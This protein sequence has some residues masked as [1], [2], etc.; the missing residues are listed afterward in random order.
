MSLEYSPEHL[1]N[2]FIVI[3][4][5]GTGSRIVAQLC[6]LI[7]SIDWVRDR[8]PMIHVFDDDVVE[9][10]N[11]TRQLFSKADV[12]KFKADAVAERYSKQYGLTVTAHKTRITDEATLIRSIRGSIMAEGYN[13]QDTV[14]RMVRP[15]L[16][17]LAVDTI[18]ARR[19]ILAAI[20]QMY[21]PFNMVV[22]DP[23]NEDSFGQV[24]V[25][26]P[27]C[28]PIHSSL[29]GYAANHLSWINNIPDFH[30]HP[31]KLN[32][33]PMPIMHY[34]QTTETGGTGSCAD[35][36]QTLALNSIMASACIAVAQSLMLCRPHQT[37]T[38]Y[39]DL[40]MANRSETMNLPWLRG[41]CQGNNTDYLTKDNLYE[42]LD[43][44]PDK[45]SK[46]EFLDKVLFHECAW[47]GTKDAIRAHLTLGQI[48]LLKN[49]IFMPCM[50]LEDFTASNLTRLETARMETIEAEE[51]ARAEAR[52]L[53]L[54]QQQADAI[55]SVIDQESVAEEV[56][57]VVESVEEVL[58]AETLAA[59]RATVAAQSRA[60]LGEA[61]V[62]D[63]DGTDYSD[64]S[65]TSGDF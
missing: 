35:L 51:K 13:L 34:M 41:V 55:A 9:A 1:Y 54:A 44:D 36:D 60:D 29:L 39:F 4:A 17:F 65:D 56:A 8:S 50:N 38:A 27:I 53:L 49:L 58:D 26:N 19:N 28:H 57:P 63:E 7:Q 59:I 45:M 10:K 43:I 20:S 33:I 14:T 48:E 46:T 31:F 6:Q 52:K 47:E 18:E 61:P 15:T 40:N 5:G 37:L 3:G 24:K 32:Y 16:C 21:F 11:L 23:G 2:N 62:E 22:I 30:I 42:L 64:D 25:F 12:G